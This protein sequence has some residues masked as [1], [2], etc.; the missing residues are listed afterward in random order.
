VAYALAAE[1]AAYLGAVL[2]VCDSGA[3][4]GDP[5]GARQMAARITEL[6]GGPTGA[7]L[8]DGSVAGLYHSGDET[9]VGGPPVGAWL[10]DARSFRMIVIDTPSFTNSPRSLGT[11]MMCDGCL[12]TVAAGLTRPADVAATLRQISGTGVRIL[13]TVLHDAPQIRAKRS[14]L[15]RRF[16]A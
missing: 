5:S 12:L 9:L 11:A 3:T 16:A 13:G 8:P 6:L 7:A 10:A 1:G 4:A 14:P 2:L 15:K